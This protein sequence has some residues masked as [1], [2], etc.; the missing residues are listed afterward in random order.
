MTA[1]KDRVATVSAELDRMSR[2]YGVS[3]HDMTRWLRSTY[4]VGTYGRVTDEQLAALEAEVQ[5]WVGEAEAE[6]EVEVAEN[7]PQPDRK[8]NRAMTPVAGSVVS[9]HDREEQRRLLKALIMPR[10]SDAQIELA[11]L[12]CEKYGFDPLLGHIVFIN[13]R[14]YVRRDGLLHHAHRSGQLDGIE[15][16]AERDRNGKWVATATVY[17]KDMSR[18]FRYSALQVEHENPASPAWQKSPRAMTIKCAEVMAL[19]RAFSVGLTAAEEMGFGDD[20]E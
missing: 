3:I 1:T 19:R 7:E 17:R 20:M 15:V 18:P 4:G 8:P 13:D 2:E 12:I 10:A 9:H 11:L 16:E 5:R 6:R 14:I